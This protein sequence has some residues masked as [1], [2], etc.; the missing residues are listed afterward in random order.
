MTLSSVVL[1]VVIA[2][3]LAYCLWP[4]PSPPGGG[5]FYWRD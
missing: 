2:G 1:L 4:N 3:L 5:D